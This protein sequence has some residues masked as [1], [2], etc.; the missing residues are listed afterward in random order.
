MKIGI[1]ARFITRHPRRGIGNYSL[2]LVNEL[3]GLD[4]T[5][6][7]VLYINQPDTEGVLPGLPNVTVRQ[8]SFPFYPLWENLILPFAAFR[9]RVDILH[10]LGNTAPLL[11]P[12]K[13]RLVLSLMDVMFLQS[14]EFIPK[15]VNR[16]QSFGRIY[17]ALVV[18]RCAK[19]ADR[20]ITISDFSRKDILELIPGLDPSRITVTWL[21]CDAVFKR[22]GIS[23]QPG[24]MRFGPR[25]FI[26]TLGAEDPRKNTLRLVKAYLSLLQKHS[27]NEDLVISGYANWQESE[28]FQLV[29]SA[30]ATERVKFLDFISIDEL[31]A[32]YRNAA[33]FVYP[34][35]Y[36][37]FGIP[38]LEA[39]SSGCPV[40]ASNVTSIP[41]VGGEAALYVD[42]RSQEDIEQ[43]IYRLIQDGAL[44]QSLITRG[45]KRA[46][47]FSWAEAARQT[48]ALYKQCMRSSQAR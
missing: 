25:P 24:D 26:F 41:E 3:V 2:N 16:Y 9:D 39:F 1:D 34:S 35:L 7:Y 40:I 48:L 22:E 21:S 32:R 27:I 8:L 17:R 10:C 28:A 43:A 20:I 47:E 13:M 46:Q 4:P 37:G 30:G 19:A 36:E 31:A 12:P 6:E 5:V 44:R 42:P 15:P 23:L 18:P 33:L 45:R 11:L 29:K 14:G 38:L